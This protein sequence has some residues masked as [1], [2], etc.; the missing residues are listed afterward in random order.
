MAWL[1]EG[2]LLVNLNNMTIFLIPKRSKTINM[3]ELR[4]IALYNVIY[5]IVTKGISWPIKKGVSYNYF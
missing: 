2:P 4:P 1:K 5:K 3:K